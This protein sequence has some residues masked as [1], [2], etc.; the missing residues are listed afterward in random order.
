MINKENRKIVSNYCVGFL[1]MLGLKEKF[2]KHAENPLTQSHDIISNIIQPLEDLQV[3]VD[4][5]NKPRDFKILLGL[6]VS[7]DI[8][9]E[10]ALIPKK[11]NW[12]DGL[13]IFSRAKN[14]S[15]AFCTHNILRIIQHCG[16]CCFSGLSGDNI[17]PIRG[18]IE[19]D[20]G[21]ELSEN[22]IF[23]AAVG[24]SYEYESKIAQYPRI[25]IG[26]KL[27]EF[28]K[29]AS[30]IDQPTNNYEKIN[31]YFAQECLKWIEEDI[32]GH[33]IVDYL[34]PDFLGCSWAEYHHLV[35]KA[36]ENI[37]NQLSMHKSK[38]NSILAIRYTCLD[39]YFFRKLPAIGLTTTNTNPS[40]I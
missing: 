29:S 13:V 1:D 12:S 24:A 33:F 19:L 7:Q 16:V 40:N 14:L 17:A 38:P 20:W 21:V 26:K 27:M 23:G 35:V 31:K 9:D 11:Q 37:K 30:C 3:R 36:I 2:H 10:L 34:K 4:S 5:L 22:E 18:A 15:D 32:D 8:I 6:G 39:A 28:L 25:V